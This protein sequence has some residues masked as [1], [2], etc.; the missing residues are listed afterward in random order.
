MGGIIC[1]IVFL[2]LLFGGLGWWAYGAYAAHKVEATRMAEIAWE[3]EKKQKLLQ[4]EIEKKQKLLQIEIKAL[5][6]YLPEVSPSRIWQDAFGN[7][8]EPTIKVDYDSEGEPIISRSDCCNTFRYRGEIYHVPLGQLLSDV[9]EAHRAERAQKAWTPPPS[10]RT[11]GM[12]DSTFYEVL[13]VPEDA[14]KSA[15]IEAFRAQAKILHPDRG[16]NAAMFR[17]A[18]RAYDTLTDENRRAA[19]DKSLHVHV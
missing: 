9:I 8:C 15:I 6:K 18:Q 16:G 4:I 10:S 19:Y 1:V 14:S 11:A 3:I 17:A 2:L 7:W 13:G 5:V 12:E